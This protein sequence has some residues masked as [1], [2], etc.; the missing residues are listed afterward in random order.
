MGQGDRAAGVVE[1]VGGGVREF[2]PT[3]IHPFRPEAPLRP[4]FPIKGKDELCFFIV[5]AAGER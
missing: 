1:G 2:A 4:T 5:T 3:G